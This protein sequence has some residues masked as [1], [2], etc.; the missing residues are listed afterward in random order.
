MSMIET[1]AESIGGGPRP[2]T[3]VV[4]SSI[5]SPRVFVLVAT[6]LFLFLVVLQLVWVVDRTYGTGGGSTSDRP[7]PWTWGLLALGVLIWGALNLRWSIQS[8][9]RAETQAAYGY[10][11]I[12]LCSGLMA[13]GLECL[14]LARG[15][16][17]EPLLY[18]F[19]HLAAPAAARPVGESRGS[20]NLKGDAGEGRKLFAMS[21][22]TCH[23]PGGD[24]LNN[25]APSLRTSEFIKTNEPA[26]ITRVVKLGR[27]VTDPQNKSGKMMPAKGGN[28]FL[29]DQQVADL[30]AFVKQLPESSAGGPAAPPAADGP[31][32][33]QLSRWVVPSAAQPPAGL[34]ALNSARD[35]IGSEA[36]LRVRAERRAQ[37]L[38]NLGLSALV[39]HG[40]FLLGVFFCSSDLLLGWLLRVP[41]R[42]SGGWLVINAWGWFLALGLWIFL[43]VL[44]NAI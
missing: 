13:F 18:D 29:T 6:L 17:Q 42:Q 39:V 9:R 15:L 16:T 7:I 44:F 31:P 28:P 33:A 3:A 22:V 26:A 25:L 30:V 19:T 21:C 23:G 8:I 14:I 32:L 40:C 11:A 34:I 38:N 5:L 4:P 12:L 10:F 35:R 1:R 36:I 41:R 37:L 43:L 24:G 2:T 27:A 20:G